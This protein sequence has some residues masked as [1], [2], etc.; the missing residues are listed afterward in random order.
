MKKII[1]LQEQRNAK[2]AELKAITATAET[3][4][5]FK[6][7]D[8]LVQWDGLKQDI[9]SLTKEI[10]TLETEER[11]NFSITKNEVQKE[12]ETKEQKE[13]RKYDLS[14]AIGEFAKGKLEGF[15]KEMHQ[16]GEREYQRFGQTANGLVIPSAVMRSFTKAGNGSHIS[17]IAQ[18]YDVI[19]DR[20]LLNSLGV[21]VYDNLTANMKLTFSDGFSAGF[22]AEGGAVTEGTVNESTDKLEAR[23]IQG[24]N[25]YSREFLA[26]SATMPQLMQDMVGSI[27]TAVAKEVIDQILAQAALAGYDPAVDAAKVL[28]WKDVMTLKGAVKHPQLVR[29][30][31]IAGG[32]LYSSLEATAKDAGS[33]RFIVDSGK[34]GAYEAV[35]MQGVVPT[36]AD[37]ALDTDT[38]PTYALIFGDM[39]R[40]YVGYFGSG[41][42][43]LVDPYTFSN[44]G[45]LKLTYSRLGDVALN[46]KAF[47]A[48]KNALL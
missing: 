4:K 23:R 8:E 22:V 41:I 24:W 18:G 1:E 32:D 33:G 20:N 28:T 7:P 25:S 44:E 39:S 37:T 30:K 26:Q 17:E 16:E 15:E 13:L 10:E 27:E 46:P 42:E 19:A 45:K 47:K 14:K 11:F 43:L 29:P 40:A 36:I 6:T 12:V 34:I 31:Y 9:E 38:N 5:R 3:E 48:I 35:D 21:T 2:V